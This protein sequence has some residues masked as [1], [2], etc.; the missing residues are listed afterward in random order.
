MA[1]L[2]DVARHA[3][4]SRTT[5]AYVLRGRGGEVGIRTETRQRVRDAASQLGYLPN[6]SARAVSTGRFNTATLIVSSNLAHSYLPNQLLCGIHDALAERRQQLTLSQIDDALLAEGGFVPRLMKE[7]M[8]DGLLVNYTAHSAGV[9]ERLKESG[10]PMVWLNSDLKHDCVRPDDYGIGRLAAERLLAAGHRRVAYMADHSPHYCTRHRWEG[11][12]DTC[13][14]AGVEPASIQHD[15]YQHYSEIVPWLQ[16][17]R[18]QAIF[19][20]AEYNAKPVVSAALSLGWRVPEDLSLIT[21]HPFDSYDSG[22]RIDTIQLPEYEMGKQ[23]VALL[24]ERIADPLARSAP[25][26]LPG[27]Y[28]PAATIA[29]PRQ[30]S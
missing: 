21:T 24:M 15:G 11:F 2:S 18:P 7:R 13:R 29:P 22:I 28:K 8:T 5:A 23:A 19:A 16:A 25:I 4:V 10:L 3:G 9:A 12:R 30:D 14:A 6:A 1:S 27:T 17:T 26:L 20:Y